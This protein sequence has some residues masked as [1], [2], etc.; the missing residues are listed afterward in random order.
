[1]LAALLACLLV[2]QDQQQVKVA[3]DPSFAPLMS[4]T[5]ADRSY[6]VYQLIKMEAEPQAA[7]YVWI[8]R[9]LPDGLRPEFVTLKEGKMC[10]W[11]GPPGKYDVDIIYTTEQGI[12]QLFCNVT[13]KGDGP[14]PPTPPDDPD[15]PDPPT[16]PDDPDEPDGPDNP[17]PP[18]PGQFGY[19]KLAFDLAK[20]IPSS[21]RTSLSMKIAD[22]Y[23]ATSAAIRAG[24]IVTVEAAFQEVKKRNQELQSDPNIVAWK[25]WFD[26]LKNQ[27]SDDWDASKFRSRD[28]VA[29]VFYEIAMGLRPYHE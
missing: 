18:E 11:T 27:I 3:A 10:V 7:G 2:V 8:I 23:E 6:E 19:S 28:D 12:S 15:K 1:M 13:I 20:K 21:K 4:V 17:Q 22:N 14:K 24:G 5:G 9:R 25:D 26:G 29:Q 16:P